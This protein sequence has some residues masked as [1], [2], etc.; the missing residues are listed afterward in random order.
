MCQIAQTR[1]KL[2]IKRALDHYKNLKNISSNIKN[3]EMKISKTE[4]T[5]S[6]Y[7]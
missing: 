7:T 3:N 5:N 4:I 2:L 1:K 6:Y